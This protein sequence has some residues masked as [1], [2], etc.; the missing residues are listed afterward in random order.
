MYTNCWLYLTECLVSCVIN[1]YHKLH[2]CFLN[3]TLVL[4]DTFKFVG[5]MLYSQ[6]SKFGCRGLSYSSNM[7]MLLVSMAGVMYVKQL[8]GSGWRI[9]LKI[10]FLQ[11]SSYILIIQQFCSP[12]YDVYWYLV[13]L[14]CRYIEFFEAFLLSDPCLLLVLVLQSLFLCLLRATGRIREYLK[15]CR[16]VN[17]INSS[18]VF[19]CVV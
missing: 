2:I 9:F 13:L 1:T 15:E 16:E 6:I 19:C 7:F 3:F 17:F 11:H 5:G 12:W 14:W 4:W 18:H 8:L 10:R